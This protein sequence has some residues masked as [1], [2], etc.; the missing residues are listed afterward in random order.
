MALK[1]DRLVESTEIG[2]Y[3][4]ETAAKGKVLVV[5][6]AGSGVGLD[7]TKNV[8]TVSA[9]S[10]GTKPLGVLLT[11]FVSVDQSRFPINWHKDQANSGD[12]AAILTRGW[13]VTGTPVAGDFAIL[14]SSGT[15]AT[16]APAAA[17]NQA[18]NPKVGRFRTIKDQDGYARLYVEL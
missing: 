11:E 17:W 2:Y 3:L 12:K 4:N 6:T 16:L 10:S 14:S 8:A 18:A 5:S 15:V 9:N 1:A 13:V 7:N